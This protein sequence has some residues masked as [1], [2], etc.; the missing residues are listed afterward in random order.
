MEESK[1]KNQKEKDE[2]LSETLKNICEEQMRMHPEIYKKN[3]EQ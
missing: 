2:I 1:E 3:G